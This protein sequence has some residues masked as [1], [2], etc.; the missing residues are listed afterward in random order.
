[1]LDAMGDL[2]LAGVSILGHYRG[3]LAGHAL[4]N[5][6][7]RAVFADPANYQITACDSRTASWLPGAGLYSESLAQAA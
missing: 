6:L 2:G 5:A 1:M 4:T 7:L 3:Y